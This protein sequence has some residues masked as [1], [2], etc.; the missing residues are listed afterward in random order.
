M[1]PGSPNAV[2]DG[3]SLLGPAI[4]HIL[5]FLENRPVDCRTESKADS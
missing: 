4:K 3:L 2:R 1:L 5:K